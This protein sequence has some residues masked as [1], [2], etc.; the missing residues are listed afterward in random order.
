MKIVILGSHGTGKSTLANKLFYHL[1]NKYKLSID[2]VQISGDDSTQKFKTSNFSDRNLRWK[3]LPDAAI[4]AFVKGFDINESTPIEAEWWIIARQLEIELLTPTPW[5]SDK[6]LIDL[7]A[8]ARYI[9]AEEKD[10][11]NIIERVAAK[12]FNYDLVLYL[13]TGEFP[14]ENNYIRSTDEKFQKVIDRIVM[15]ILTEHQIPFYTIRGDVE[16]RFNI[17]K[18]IVDKTFGLS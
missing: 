4:D 15:D 6:C 12:N 9:F 17:A 11:L 16:T 8:Y 2:N 7:L 1:K 10:F 5:I 18:E 3:F 13:P 14:L